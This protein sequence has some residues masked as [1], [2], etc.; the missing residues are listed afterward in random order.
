M[1]ELDE[2]LGKIYKEDDFYH[3]EKIFYSL[4]E[5]MDDESTI[6][7]LSEENGFRIINS[8]WRIEKN[9]FYTID[10]I[11]ADGC[12]SVASEVRFVYAM[13]LEYTK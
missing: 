10:F 8:S 9:P 1:R 13:K 12:V 4:E 2:D 3:L 5:I 7:S 6:K 11:M